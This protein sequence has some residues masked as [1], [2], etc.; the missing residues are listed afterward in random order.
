MD[1]IHLLL[2]DLRDLPYF[3]SAT[4]DITLRPKFDILGPITLRWDAVLIFMIARHH[5]V[6][7]TVGTVMFASRWVR[8]RAVWDS[9]EW[10]RE[11]GGD[12]GEEDGDEG[13]V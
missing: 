12:E 5:V 4:K 3:C 7:L 8:V 2:D 1:D 9:R 13:G 10:G 6:T 11:G